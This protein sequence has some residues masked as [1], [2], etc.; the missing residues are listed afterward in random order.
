VAEKMTALTDA[1]ISV[2]PNAGL[3]EV[4]DGRLVYRQTPSYMADM[5]ERMAALGVNLLG[6]CCGVDA[7]AIAA[8]AG[9][10]RG[11]PLAART[12]SRAAAEAAEPA[13]APA[14]GPPD[15]SFLRHLGK[16]PLIVAELDPPRGMKTDKVLDGARRLRE[17]GAHLISMAENPLA[18][19]RLGNVGMAYLVKR[20][21]GAEPLV[22]FTGR[23]RNTIGLHSDLMGAAALGI[24]HVLAVTGDP[25]GARESGITSVYDVNSI[26][27]CRI[28]SALNAGRTLHGVDTGRAAGFTL[29]V[30]F[31]PNFRT[32]TGQLKKLRQKVEAGAQF[33]LSQLVYD[34]ER[35]AEI[36]EAVEPCGIPVL[37]GVMPLVSQRNA[38]FMHHE[39]PG[40]RLPEEVLARMAKHPTG[41]D[42]EKEGLDIAREL[43]EVALRSGAP[44]V[45]LVTPFQR[46]DLTAQLIECVRGAWKH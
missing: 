3:P 28:V 15:G 24:R 44:G 18:S 36:R 13:P 32:M 43:I 8:I 20:D 22:H 6:G 45:Y 29:G 46:A 14:A 30:A 21:A 26:G 16:E 4:R 7:K 27:I 25:A 12:K 10:V 34:R 2:Y 1:P 41:E 5:A 11:R 40:V 37:P 9:R 42:A 31:N 23:D 35:M 17:A 19:I 38:H 39:V 33:A